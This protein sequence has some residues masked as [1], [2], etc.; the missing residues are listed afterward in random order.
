[1]SCGYPEEGGIHLLLENHKYIVILSSTGQDLL[2]I[3]LK[4]TK[5][6]M[7]DHHRHASKKPLNGISLVGK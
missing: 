5:H 1:M 7:L 4:T 3:N 6:S 2:K